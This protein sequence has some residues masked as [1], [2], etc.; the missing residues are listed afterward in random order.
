MHTISSAD[1]ASDASPSLRQRGLGSWSIGWFVSLAVLAICFTL[2]GVAVRSATAEPPARIDR[3]DGQATP[4]VALAERT[5]AAWAGARTGDWS[6]VAMALSDLPEVSGGSALRA[7][8]NRLQANLQRREATRAEE[9]AKVE[10]DLAKALEEARGEQEGIKLSEALRSAVE[11]HMLTPPSRRSEL[12]A[13]PRYQALIQRAATAAH[14]AEAEGQWIIAN[15]LFSRLNALLETEATYKADARRLAER[16][17]MIR[18]YVPQRFWELRNERRILDGQ[19]P[20]PPFN[21]IGEDFNQKLRGV[22]SSVVARAIGQAARQH[23]ERVPLRDLLVGGYESVRTMASTP[24]L[25][26]AF[27]GLNDPKARQDMVNFIDTQIA[28]VKVERND[29]RLNVAAH[30]ERLLDFNRTS[31]RILEAALLHEFG[32]GAFSKLDEFSQIIWPDELARF[33]RM[34]E[35][36]FVGVGIQIQ[37]DEESQMIRVVTPIEGTPAQRAGIRAGD[38]IKKI[39]DVSAIGMTLDQAVEQITGRPGTEVTLTLEREREDITFTL[40]RERIPIRTV[41][42]WQRT[43]PGD[44]DWNWFIDRDQ[45]IG[46]VRLTQFND[47]TTED[48]HAALNQMKSQGVRGLILD[49]RFNP[50]G[51][52]DQAIKVANTFVDAGILVYTEGAGGVRRQTEVADPEQVRAKGLP[53]V[54][55]I[56]EGSA[57]ASEIVSGAIRHYADQGRINAIVIGERTFGKGSVQNV[58]P[59]PPSTQM[60]L[61]TQYYFVPSGQ[62]IHRRPNATTWGVDPHLRVEMLPKQISDALLLRQDA[63][64]PPDTRPFPRPTTGRRGE[65]REDRPKDE[66]FPPNPARL[67]TEGLDLQLETALVLLQARTVGQTAIA[68]GHVEPETVKNPG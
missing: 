37:L 10:K 22:D 57:S 20:L 48:L 29:F 61:T 26:P 12:V 40:T 8:V 58:M 6:A 7:A 3:G 28:A 30:L 63:D 68:G 2:T 64:L 38:L 17:N 56:N 13:S 16:L 41:R 39:N 34:T 14:R 1:P 33:R 19:S 66:P 24:D 21:P 60:K 43:G 32:N 42:G 55:L 65:K 9:M 52:L 31:T 11:L 4:A 67:L 35:G 23:V 18:L 44:T 50:G 25:T 53:L 49:L 15:E 46:Y 51:L 36:S 47:S 5:Q 54:V 45:R 27:P 59:L 62:I